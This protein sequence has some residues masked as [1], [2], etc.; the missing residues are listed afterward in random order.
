MNSIRISI[1]I[2]VI[3][4]SKADAMECVKFNNPV[5]VSRFEF[6]KLRFSN[7]VKNI[8]K[9]RCT[10]IS[11]LLNEWL[12]DIVGVYYPTLARLGVELYSSFIRLNTLNASC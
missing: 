7:D 8:L 4:Y 6:G 5:C 11:R 9:A 2:H 12:S 3:V 1:S 10:Q